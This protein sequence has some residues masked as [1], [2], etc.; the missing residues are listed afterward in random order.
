M[1]YKTSIP[2]YK[3]P[4]SG[5][6]MAYARAGNEEYVQGEAARQQMENENKRNEITVVPV[7]HVQNTNH[8]LRMQFDDDNGSSLYGKIFAITLANPQRVHQEALQLPKNQI[9]QL[10]DDTSIHFSE[11]P[12]QTSAQV[13]AN[14]KKLV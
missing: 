10:D 5:L 14:S 8:K 7:A 3:T 11:Y 12:I 1:L 13:G 9:N 6:S 4:F 2:G